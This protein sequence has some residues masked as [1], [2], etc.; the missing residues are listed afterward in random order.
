MR[1]AMR[2]EHLLLTTQ[3]SEANSQ[4]SSFLGRNAKERMAT[5]QVISR[6]APV[7]AP[8]KKGRRL[9]P[10]WVLAIRI[11]FSIAFAVLLFLVP[12]LIFRAT[13]LFLLLPTLLSMVTVGSRRYSFAI[14]L[15]STPLYLLLSFCLA[16]LYYGGI[17]M[18]IVLT[19]LQPDSDHFILVGGALAWT[20]VLDPVRIYFQEKIDQRF[21][22]RNREMREAIAAFATALREE[23]D[24]EQIRER[25]LAMIQR[26]L[27]PYSLELWVRSTLPMKQANI[28]RDRDATFVLDNDDPFIAYALQHPGALNLLERLHLTS[29]LL[30]DLR[31]R[32]V[33]V[34]LPLT[35]QGELIALLILGPRLVN[36]LHNRLINI[37][38]SIIFHVSIVN[39]LLWL[40]LKERVRDDDLYT[41][42]ELAMLSQLAPQ[43]APALRVAQMVQERQEQV[44]VRE[45][46]EQELRTAQA[47]QQ[48]FLPKETPA[49]TDWQLIPYYQP[50]REVGGDFYDVAALEDGQL[51]LVIGDVT[52]KGVP[53]ALV[54][55][56]V[57]T[58]LRSAARDSASPAQ[59]LERVNELLV[60][61]IPSGMF[62]TCFYALLDP[63]DGR[64]RYANAGHEA[65]YRWQNSEV[66]ELW[67]TGMPLGMM[68]GS[69]Y[70]EFEATIAPG[71]SLL[72]YSDGLI[73][74]H[75]PSGEM[76]GFP[77]LQALL[78]IPTHK[79]TL[80]DFV[81]AHLHGFTGVYWEQEDDIT[82]LAL[83]RVEAEA[84]C[85]C[86]RNECGS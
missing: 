53:A 1:E 26:T 80:L 47:I 83:Q 68:P 43:V 67:A 12:W 9:D 39:L 66:S 38:F 60:A 55:A 44:R 33:E 84:E 58:L 18:S 8:P 3:Q 79:P 29:P 17:T 81:L 31:E 59:I 69:R 36:P 7:P 77:R 75:N 5:F 16:L 42:Q 34:V 86:P 21:N 6:V 14:I 65:P 54:M 50:A 56:T 10:R 28:T 41:R 27:H 73:E 23:I 82:L 4:T 57:L 52:D 19:H 11:G 2:T 49:L 37:F 72:F 35:S 71:E 51:A 85:S 64:L 25:F 15:E 70:D 22:T 20:V 13:F 74:A 61:E 32:G 40:F 76:F 46:I 48:A 78:S 45:R 30:Q 24:L 63:R 62:V